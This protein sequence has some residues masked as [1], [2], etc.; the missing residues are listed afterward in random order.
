MGAQSTAARR[1][2]DLKADEQALPFIGVVRARSDHRILSEDRHVENVVLA[3]P[4]V[5]SDWNCGAL[6]TYLYLAWHVALLGTARLL[7]YLGQTELV[8]SSARRVLVG[9]RRL[10]LQRL[11]PSNGPVK[12]GPRLNDYLR[13]MS[14]LSLGILLVI[15]AVLDPLSQGG[16]RNSA[17]RID[18]SLLGDLGIGLCGLRH[19]VALPPRREACQR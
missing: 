4:S 8:P 16:H 9:E 3:T 2:A 7:K 6:R 19:R 15:Y 10:L 12:K 13:Q 5:W 1:L 14:C 17:H 11:P 18:P